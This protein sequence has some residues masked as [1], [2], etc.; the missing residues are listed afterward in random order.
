MKAST[1]ILFLLYF[2]QS[3]V[4]G[5][6]NN[7]TLHTIKNWSVEAQLNTMSNSVSQTF[8]P[9]IFYMLNEKNH[10]GLRTLA[11]LN[12]GDGTYSFF[13]VYRHLFSLNKTSLFGELS[14]GANIYR[15]DKSTKSDKSFG[16]NIGI[17]HHLTE[18]ISFGGLAGAEWT[19]TYLTQNM[20]D[21]YKFDNVIYARLSLFG[22]LSF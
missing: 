4:Y 18:D 9:T 6:T 7:I 11:P 2:F 8:G 21:N 20:A 17:I 16:T 10:L 12:Y 15:Q 1:I 19:Q 22:I 13:G 5:D 14:W 3:N